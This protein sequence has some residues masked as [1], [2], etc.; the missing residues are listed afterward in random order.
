MKYRSVYHCSFIIRV[1]EGDPLPTGM[2]DQFLKKENYHVC[3]VE[4]TPTR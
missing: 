3:V 2:F 1:L 4:S